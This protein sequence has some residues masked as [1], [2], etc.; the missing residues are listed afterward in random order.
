MTPKHIY[1][2]AFTEHS[3]RCYLLIGGQLTKEENQEIRSNAKASQVTCESICAATEGSKVQ[4]DFFLSAQNSS[5]DCVSTNPSKGSCY[6]ATAIY[7]D[8][9][10]P[11]VLIFRNFRDTFLL[12]TRIGIGFVK[13]YYRYSPYLVDKLSHNYFLRKLI[14]IIILNPVCKT[15]NFIQKQK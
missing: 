11:Q 4:K 7:G 12:K 13:L 9:D 2:S 15:L 8:Y 6:I 14:R 1:V 10:A 5:N 3:G